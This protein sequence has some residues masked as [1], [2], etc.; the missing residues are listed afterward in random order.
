VAARCIIQGIDEIDPASGKSNRQRLTEE[1][2]DVLAQ[3][4]FT[5][6]ELKLEHEALGERVSEKLG[7]MQAWEDHFKETQPHDK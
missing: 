7:K 5:A 2:A 4:F 3:C 6:T 1:I